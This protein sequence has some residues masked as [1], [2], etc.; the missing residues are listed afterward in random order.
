MRNTQE[1]K[2]SM[3]DAVKRVLM[4]FRTR[5]SGMAGFA[6]AVAAFINKV[7][8]I[9]TT[10]TLQDRDISGIPMDK[11]KHKTILVDFALMVAGAIHAYANS[12]ENNEMEKAVRNS[13]KKLLRMRDELLSE[14][15]RNIHTIAQEQL[16]NL[17]GFGITQETVNMLMQLI[18][19]YQEKV[20][21]PRV[22]RSSKNTFTSLLPKLYREAD[23][24]LK[25]QLD[26]MMLQFKSATTAGSAST[27]TVE[28]SAVATDVPGPIPPASADFYALYFQARE[29]IDLGRRSFHFKEFI[30]PISGSITIPNV[31]NQTIA[32]N[33]GKTT[34]TWMDSLSDEP[35]VIEVGD[36]IT[37]NSPSGSIVVTNRSS[38]KK[39]KIK[40]KVYKV[41]K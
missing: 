15:C 2:L 11:L 32:T 38:V 12:I 5:W 1:N 13:R 19:R 14:R 7:T 26:K 41:K 29:I 40:V 20:P 17:A 4:M 34:I 3:Y 22:A 24:I 36:Y 25:F 30:I 8:A 31:V 6:A 35:L 9:E 21:E 23:R 39:G 27:G 37:V 16:G 28:A 10:G 33:I 18:E